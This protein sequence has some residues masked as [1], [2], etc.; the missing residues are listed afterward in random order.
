M[1]PNVLKIFRR[2]GIEQRL[3]QM[4]SHPDFWFSR[5]AESGDYLSRIELGAFARREYGAAYVT[6]HRGDLQ[7]LQ[8]SALQPGTLHFGK[9]LS[10]IEDRGDEV[11]LN[12]VDGT[13]AHADI[14]IGADGI[15]SRIREHLLGAEAPTYSGWVAHRALIRGEKLAKYN[16]TFED[17]V[18]WWSADRHLMVYY[19]TQRRDEYYYVSGVPHPASI[20]VAASSTAA[21]KRCSRPSPATTRSCRR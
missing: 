7:A 6:V 4:A 19:T 13:S 9:C 16:L 18:K 5:D 3:E 12:F 20:S 2:L 1:G 10:K 15:N 8:L 17:C 14:V 11:V 21:A